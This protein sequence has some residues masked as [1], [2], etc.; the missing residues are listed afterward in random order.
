MLNYTKL[1]CFYKVKTELFNKNFYSFFRCVSILTREDKYMQFEVVLNNEK[2]TF[3]K[4]VKLLSLTNGDT[5]IICASVNGRIREL[6]YDLY[7]DSTV[8]FLTVKD[9]EAMGIYERGIRFIFAMA[10]HLCYPKLRFKLTY[11][12]SRS[13]FAQIIDGNIKMVTLEMTNNIEKKMKEIVQENFLFERIIVTNEKAEEIY[14]EYN[15]FDK[16]EIV[17]YRPEKTVHLYTANGYFNYMYGKMVP[18]AGYLKDFKLKQYSNGLIIQYPRSEFEGKIPPFSD[19]PVFRDTL[20]HSQAWGNLV[21]L[22]TVVGIN[23]HIKSSEAVQLIN[24]CEDRHNK[25]LSELGEKIEDNIDDIRV[26]CIAGPS[27]SGKTTFADRLT[28]ELLSRGIKP[29][30][31]SIDDYYKKRE[32]VPKDEDGNY[33]FECLNALD[34]DL[35]N[36]N[37]NDL[38]EGKTVDLPVFSFKENKRKIGRTVTIGPEDPIIIEGIHALNEDMTPRIPKYIKFKIYIAP[39]AQINID[40]ENPISLTDIRLIRRMVRDN[41]YRGAGAEETIRMWPSVRKGEFKWIYNTQEDADYVFDS[42]LNYEICVLKK[43]ALPLLQKI[44]RD[45]EY[46]PDAERL[47]KLIKYFKDIDDKW[48]PCNSLLKEFIGGSCYRDCLSLE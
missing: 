32:D 23:S 21:N 34:V 10:A 27:S 20:I 11:S 26:I 36:D 45:G 1:Y 44:D 40:D 43:Y 47:I 3:D 18:S 12:I 28:V 24:M 39:Q 7:Y 42:F 17:Q 37:V 15:L 30:R 35:F 33:D 16:A 4:K 29:I 13:I 9:H 19:E 46:G 31:I 22:S 48:I 8:H 2:Q 14:K 41:K 25:M 5:N 6:D 38:L